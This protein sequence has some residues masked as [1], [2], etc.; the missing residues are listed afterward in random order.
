MGKPGEHRRLLE[1]HPEAQLW[2]DIGLDTRAAHGLCKA[3][4]WNLEQLGRLTREEARAIP[5]IGETALH[6]CEEALGRLF[7]SPSRYWKDRRIPKRGIQ[8]FL[9][10][11]IE[12]QEQLLK[13]PREEVLRLQGMTPALLGQIE[14]ALGISFD[15]PFSYWTECGLPPK[16]AEALNEMGI[17]NLEELEAT[18]PIK[19]ESSFNALEYRIINVVLRRFKK[20]S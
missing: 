13:M 10:E 2:I 18:S 1:V 8:I 4:V 20:R 15:F 14:S 17:L 11:G 16:T 6:I 5:G 7:P 9:R 12:K 3:G 19:L